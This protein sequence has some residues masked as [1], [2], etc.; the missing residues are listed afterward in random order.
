M[1]SRNSNSNHAQK[2]SA[3]F[4]ERHVICGLEGVG[5]D[6]AIGKLVGLID[7][8]GHL[9]APAEEVRDA[10]LERE[11]LVST[12]IMAGLA[13]PHARTDAV[14][15]VRVAV[16]TS[17]KGIDFG[18][19]NM[20]PA[21]IV[22]L[23][24]TPK[25]ATGDY[26]QALAAVAH[27]FQRTGAMSRVT[28]MSK[29]RE[30]WDFFD[31]GGAI[32]EYV[33]A[34][35]MMTSEFLH[36]RPADRLKRAI[37]LFCGHPNIDLPVIDDDGDLVGRVT[38]ADLLRIALPEYIL[39]LDDLSPI[40]H[41]EPFAEV[42]RDEEATYVAEVMNEEF[43]TVSEDAPAIQVARELMRS[44]ARQVMVVRGKKLVGVIRL[45]DFLT[46]VLRG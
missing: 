12:Q 37:D 9:R 7:A 22:V 3:L 19:A 8:T 18:S 15:T 1:G 31:T 33:T 39:W 17:P 10:I 34:K 41:F 26:L 25:L 20:G 42:L 28:A 4:D 36:V 14:E 38:Q 23:I 35:D 5:R 21:H 6:A 29:Q 30:V 11:E 24:L 45:N 27:S 16:A 46:R 44:H 2:L 40:L 43:P 13:I 32:P